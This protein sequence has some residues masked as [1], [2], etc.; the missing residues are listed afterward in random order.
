M[1]LRGIRLSHETVRLW[2]QRIGTN[3]ALKMRVHRRGCSHRKW[4]MD[5]TYLKVKG[6]DMYLYRAIDKGGNLVDVY[7]SDTRDK[8]AVEE[9]FKACEATTGPH[10]IQ[11]TT[12]KEPAFS[13]TIKKAFGD[14]VK[15][16]D[17]KYMNNVTEQPHRGIKSRYRPMKGFQDSGCAMIFCTVFEEIKQFFRMKNKTQSQRRHDFAPRFQEFETMAG[18]EA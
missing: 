7:L 8:K 1:A 9:F 12:D 18:M 11:V 13:N 15:H 3:I 4:N 14:D 17:S 2:S 6:Y 16:R 5:I 10:P